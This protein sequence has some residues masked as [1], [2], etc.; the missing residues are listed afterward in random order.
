MISAYEFKG[1][2]QF[3]LQCW[4][5][6]VLHVTHLPTII[7]TL[8]S[9]LCS[10]CSPGS[11]LLP[12]ISV[13]RALFPRLPGSLLCSQTALCAYLSCSPSVPLDWG[14]NANFI[15]FPVVLQNVL[16]QSNLTLPLEGRTHACH[17]P[18]HLF[19]VRHA[20]GD[21]YYCGLVKS[22]LPCALQG[23]PRAKQNTS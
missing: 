4:Q 3:S 5:C 2:T 15:L 20:A 16:C 11:R 7:F 1:G 6:I 9:C 22:C 23:A 19:H 12:F 8:L 21:K 17:S 10:C 14:L 13:S 18:L